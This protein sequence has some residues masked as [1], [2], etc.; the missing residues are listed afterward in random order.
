VRVTPKDVILESFYGSKDPESLVIDKEFFLPLLSWLRASVMQLHA[1]KLPQSLWVSTL[2]GALR[3]AAKKSLTRVHGEAPI[4]AWSLSDFQLAVAS[5]VPEHRTQFTEAALAMHF[6]AKSLCDDIARFA[7]LMKNGEIECNSKFIFRNLQTKLLEARPDILSVAASQFNLHFQFSEDFDQHISA[8]QTIAER[9]HGEGLLTSWVN[10]VKP[11]SFT[12]RTLVM[13]APARRG[14][15][16]RQGA[17]NGRR[18]GAGPS[19]QKRSPMTREE[20]EA[21]HREFTRLAREHNRCYGCGY[22]VCKGELEGHKTQCTHNR[23]D[24]RRRMGQVAAQ[25]KRGQDPNKKLRDLS[26]A[27]K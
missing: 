25:V 11:N 5:L 13:Q 18:Q 3:E 9:M 24:F 15:T 8:A 26:E 22:L 17:G 19:N 6:T 20:R 1:S 7:L 27:N 2:L 16:P 12:E 10:K 4:D 23:D 14:P 21:Q